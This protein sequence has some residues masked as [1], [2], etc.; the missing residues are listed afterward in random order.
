LTQNGRTN[1]L[2]ACVRATV[3]TALALMAAATASA[4][5]VNL[6]VAKDAT[7]RGGSYAN[8]RHGSDALLA[9]RASADGSYVRRAA[10]T[11]DTETTIPAGATIQSATLVL[12][13]RGGNSEVRQ[14][15]AFGIPISFDE[16]YVTWNA[17][18]SGISWS[19]AGGDTTGSGAYATASGV[20]GSQVSFDVTQHVQSVV[21]G[22]YGSRYAR[23][24]V[25]D[26]GGSS[27]DSY[28]EFHSREST[29]STRR[30][31]LI[32]NY[33][34]SS[35]SGSTGSTSPSANAATADSAGDIIMGAGHVSA[36][37]GKWTI[38]SDSSAIGSQVVKHPDA[39][40]A[41]VT[42]A[43][44]SPSNYFEMAFE[45]KAGTAYRL[46]VHGKAQS[47]Y[48]GNDSVFV[49]FSASV[50]SGGS[51]TY[52]IGTTSATEM[53]LEDCNGCGLS[54]WQWQDN[55]WGTGV[56]GP[57]IYFAS[58][59][60]H[61]IRV[62]TREDGLS[63]DRIVLSPST[64]MSSAPGGT[65]GGG[66]GSGG[67]S[68]GST[69]GSTTTTL[70]VLQWNI[71]H[72]VG[73]DGVYDIDTIASWIAKTG[74]NVV[75][76]N[77]V[78][79]YTG[80][81]NEDQPARFASLLKSKTGK[82][83][84]YTFAQRD[85]GTNGQGNL[86][87]TIFPIDSSADHQ[88]SYS[89]SVAQIRLT[90]NGRTINIFSTHLDAD[91]AARRTAQI[92]ELKSWAATFPEQRIIA[93]D[94]NAWPGATEIT[95]MTSG[96]YDTWAVAKANGT[97]VAYAGNEAGNTRNSRIDYVFQSKGATLLVVKASQVYDTR[98]SSGVAASD[99][100]PLMTTFTVK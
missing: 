100:K 94:F 42:A 53:N 7:I 20:V 37:A 14:L 76:L 26:G 6:T 47:D 49:Q 15:G 93:G 44:A 48:W 87:L 95:G 52:R 79:K 66:T 78:E 74:A 35:S 54:G 32:V 25:T 50:T 60:T 11:F 51:A 75:S 89:R 9:T 65:S 55:G 80:W 61:R 91:S 96:H 4:Q 85:S 62:Q 41:K 16:P 33:G 12:T 90:I 22:T 30:P 23:F 81:G 99:H 3:A 36:R 71:H 68:G 84:N 5:S 34:S 58:T 31:R 64:Y 88:L 63:I 72:G 70:K 8:T 43:S 46:W 92:A 21:K 86:L 45:A 57:K 24:L 27:R 83:W 59:G 2:G 18:K 38:A 29:D 39:A 10:L 82:T 28:K 77:E 56:L 69:S 97:A 19:N 1:S 73:T 13:V 40:A 17:R 98:D 67:T